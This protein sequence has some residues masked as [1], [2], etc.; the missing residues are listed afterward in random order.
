MFQVPLAPRT[1]P[2][3]KL[4]FE[5]VSR[6]SVDRSIDCEIF[7][8]VCWQVGKR[9]QEPVANR[10]LQ[11]VVEFQRHSL[12]ALEPVFSRQLRRCSRARCSITQR[13][14]TLMLKI[15]QISSLLRPSTSRMRKSAGGALRQRRETVVKYFPEVVALDQFGGRRMPFSRRVIV[16]PM[17]LP[18]SGL[19]KNSLCSGPSSDSSPSGASRTALPKVIDNLVFQDSDEPGS[20]RASSLEMLCKPSGPREKSLVSRLRRHYCRAGEK[21][22]T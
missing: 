10:V 7:S 16:V 20:L 13:L 5:L 11:F 14:F 3:M 22:H 12:F 18:G 8:T 4:K 17:T 15:S 1:N 9:A 21:P 2:Q 19:S 6:T